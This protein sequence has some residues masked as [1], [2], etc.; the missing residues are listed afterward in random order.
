MTINKNITLIG[1]GKLGSNL[2]KQMLKRELG[3]KHIITLGKRRGKI[4][5]NK[6]SKEILETSD[7]IIIC[8]QDKNILNV[9]DEIR[10]LKVSL[11]GKIFFH[12]SGVLTS[13]IFCKLNNISAGSFHPAQ[14]FYKKELNINLFENIYVA[15][16]GDK[17][18]LLFANKLAKSLGAKPFVID[19]S[20]KI[21][22]HLLCVFSSNYILSY[23]SL[24]KK[25]AKRA[26]IEENRWY[27]IIEPL[28]H[29]TLSNIEK[30]HIEDSMTG[31]IVRYELGTIEA[32]LKSIKSDKELLSLYKLLGIKTSDIAMNIGSI[33][34]RQKD[35]INQL[36]K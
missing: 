17:E 35:K 32:H 18:Y 9:V 1:N 5:S 29:T 31:P 10:K 12:T 2:A 28:L 34:K 23:F 6:I 36:L 14:T 24:V 22:Y 11:K 15:I 33:T 19:K 4:F 3:L 25:I 13:E 16:E 20:Q 27:K 8:V 30:N 7:V 21:L 26:S